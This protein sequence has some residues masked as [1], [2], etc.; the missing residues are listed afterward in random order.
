MP[1]WVIEPGFFSSPQV[2]GALLIGGVAAVISAVVGVFTVLRGQSFAGHALADTAATGGS[3][4]TLIGV[5]PLLGFVIGAVGGTGAM[6]ASGVRH[7]RGRDLATG[8]VLGG[9]IGLASLFLYLDTATATTGATQQILFGS[10]FATAPGTVPMVIALGVTSLA[11]IAIAYRP[12]LYSS[13]S[14]EIAAAG[15][16]PVRL[17]S[18]AYMLALAFA[19]ALSSLAV[20]A[21]LSTALLIGPPATAVRVTRRVTRALLA[22]IALGIFSTWLGV[23]LAYDSATWF[24][25]NNGLPVSFFIVAVIFSLYLAV[26]LL[27]LHRRRGR[28]TAATARVTA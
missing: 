5:N 4:M 6:E 28:R 26:D 10:V 3:G 19:V 7:A 8:I 13:I 9:S 20:G 23:L 1:R 14:P 27:A 18:L 17:V 25:D 24:T 21:I 11:I 2:Q 12:L 15:G 16:I 22:A